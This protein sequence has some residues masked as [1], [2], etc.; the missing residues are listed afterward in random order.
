MTNGTRR[1]PP[2]TPPTPP[3]L[4]LTATQRAI[5]SG[6]AVDPQRT[7]QPPHPWGHCLCRSRA[8]LTGGACSCHCHG[9]AFRVSARGAGT[10]GGVRRWGRAD[11]SPKLGGVRRR[12]LSREMRAVPR[13][14]TVRE[15]PVASKLRN[16][17]E[18]AQILPSAT[19]GIDQTRS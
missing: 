19:R 18:I 1:T 14:E 11:T 17:P 5:Q 8:N 16:F 12:S 13:H 10:D 4:P 6:W 7:P 3:S 9:R 2:Q 15:P